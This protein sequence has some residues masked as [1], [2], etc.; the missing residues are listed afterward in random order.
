[1]R[2]MSSGQCCADFVFSVTSQGHHVWSREVASRYPGNAH[3]LHWL[4]RC[5]V[6]VNELYA[7]SMAADT[8]VTCD[9][10]R[11]RNE[12]VSVLQQAL[13]TMPSLH[14]AWSKLAAV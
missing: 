3:A 10:S 8:S 6:Q 11:C 2:C 5:L 13:R 14:E 1:M 4:G 7:S 9:L 12:G